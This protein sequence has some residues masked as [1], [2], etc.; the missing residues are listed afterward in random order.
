MPSPA[1]PQQ[2][3]TIPDSSYVSALETPPPA[4]YPTT[5]VDTRL[6]VP[7]NRAL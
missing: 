6:I 7:A 4:K 5:S 2:P 1:M 3:T